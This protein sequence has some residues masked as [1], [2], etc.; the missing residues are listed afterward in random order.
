VS[1]PQFTFV[2]DSHCLHFCPPT[3]ELFAEEFS[4]FLVL[5]HATIVLIFYHRSI[6]VVHEFFQRLLFGV[7]KPTHSHFGL[8]YFHDELLLSLLVLDVIS[9][10]VGLLLDAACLRVVVEVC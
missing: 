7:V 5:E 1:Q 6:P 8:H 2:F 9:F 10:P 3:H 4:S